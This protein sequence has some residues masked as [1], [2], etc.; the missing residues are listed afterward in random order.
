[1][2]V[3]DICKYSKFCI[4][5]LAVYGVL[6]F[7]PKDYP[8]GRNKDFLSSSDKSLHKEFTAASW[9]GA[10]VSTYLWFRASYALGAGGIWKKATKIQHSYSKNSFFGKHL[11]ECV[12][13]AYFQLPVNR[14]HE[15]TAWILS[16]VPSLWCKLRPWEWWRLKEGSSWMQVRKFSIVTQQLFF[17]QAFKNRHRTGTDF[18]ILHLS[19]RVEEGRFIETCQMGICASYY[20]LLL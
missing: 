14:K 3:G 16:H 11:K 8:P 6:D 18:A 5:I 4:C 12:A 1:M 9:V 15:K 19:I 17:W 13:I 2:R 7:S 10:V 20:G